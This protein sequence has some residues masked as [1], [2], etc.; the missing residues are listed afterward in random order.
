[1]ERVMN[2]ILVFPFLLIPLIASEPA[3]SFQWPNG[4]KVA[5]SLTYDDGIDT[6][7]QNAIPDLTAAGLRGT[8]YI[9][10]NSLTPERLPAWRKAA[11]AGHE[12]AN[13]SGFHPCSE[14]Y[15]WISEEYATQNYTVKRILGEIGLVN[16]LLHAVDG[17]TERSFAY[18]CVETV[19]G[20]QSYIEDLRASNMFVAARGGDDQIADVK[21]VDVF[22]VPSWAVEGASGPEMIQFVEKAAKTGGLAVFMFHGVGGEYIK[23]SSPAHR[24]LLGHLSKNNKRIWTAPFIEVMQHVL[25]ERSRLKDQPSPSLQ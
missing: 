8:F 4:A 3:D 21:T 12:L 6:Q 19:V 14:T 5:V 24:E 2:T 10:G 11:A 18:P 22:N 13:H 20:G 15:D 9:T 17:K 16:L 25:N 7:L 23:V 1:M